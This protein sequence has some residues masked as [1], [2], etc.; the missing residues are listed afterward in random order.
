MWAWR[1]LTG[2]AAPKSMGSSE[3]MYGGDDAMAYMRGDAAQRRYR[4][5]RSRST[6]TVRRRRPSAHARSAK[7]RGGRP[8]KVRKVGVHPRTGKILFRGKSGGRYTRGAR[9]HKNYLP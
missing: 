7:R 1:A 6:T 9:G 8:T 4:K 2:G 5:R 3:D